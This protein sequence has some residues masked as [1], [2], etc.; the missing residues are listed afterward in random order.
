MYLV[1]GQASS[2]WFGFVAACW[3]ESLLFSLLY[4][5]YFYIELIMRAPRGA[6]QGGAQADCV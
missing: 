4:Q 1:I 5:K 2:K 3:K 6:A